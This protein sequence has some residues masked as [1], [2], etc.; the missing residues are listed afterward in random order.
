MKEFAFN[1]VG[2]IDRFDS[3]SIRASP[4]GKCRF[5]SI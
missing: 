3:H 5:I 4:S 2:I 1:S